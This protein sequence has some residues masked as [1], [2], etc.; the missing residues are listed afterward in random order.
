MTTE[1][2]FNVILHTHIWDETNDTIRY[3]LVRVIY[4]PFIP[5]EGLQM[6]WNSKL[7]PVLF[8]RSI[9]YNYESGYF[10]VEINSFEHQKYKEARIII[11][12]LTKEDWVAE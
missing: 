2:H 7:L 10:D 12:Q 4:L 8:F 6:K 5:F 1:K 11:D 9:Q 3:K